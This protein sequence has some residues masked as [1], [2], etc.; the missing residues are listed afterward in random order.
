MNAV[1][2]SELELIPPVIATKLDLGHVALACL[3]WTSISQSLTFQ[4]IT[5]MS[6]KD[7][8]DF[9]TLKQH[10]LTKVASYIEL[11]ASSPTADNNPLQLLRIFRQTPV[12]R[13]WDARPTPARL[14]RAF[15]T[16]PH[17]HHK[18]DTVANFSTLRRTYEGKIRHEQHEDFKR[19]TRVAG[20]VAVLEWRVRATRRRTWSK[21]FECVLLDPMDEVDFDERTAF[22]TFKP[23]IEVFGPPARSRKQRGWF[24]VQRWS[25]SDLQPVCTVVGTAHAVKHTATGEE[26]PPELLDRIVRSFTLYDDDARSSPTRRVIAKKRDLSHVALVCRRWASVGQSLIF[27]RVALRCRTDVDDLV[28]LVQHP[29]SKVASYI[30][31]VVLSPVTESHLAQSTQAREGHRR[32][33][34]PWIHTISST[35]LPSI[36]RSRGARIAVRVSGSPTIKRPLSI[37][38]HRLP[39]AVPGLFS[40]IEYLA[41]ADM[42]LK[43][44]RDLIYVIRQLPSLAAVSCQNVTWGG[45]NGDIPSLSLYP[46]RIISYMMQG[47]TDNMAA[48]WLSFLVPPTRS[49]HWEKHDANQMCRLVS[50]LVKNCDPGWLHEC[51][52]MASRLPDH[53]LLWSRFGDPRMPSLRVFHMPLV[54]GHARRVRALVIEISRILT[55]DKYKQSNYYTDWIELD[56]LAASLPA[57]QTLLFAFSSREAVVQVH[58][59]V[60]LPKMPHFRHSRRLKYALMTLGADGM[61]QITEVY[62]EHDIVKE[63]GK[64]VDG[65]SRYEELL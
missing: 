16:P 8:D 33:Q 22:P 44:L 51:D 60:V 20:G 54:P 14:C 53:L 65:L 45:S 48:A 27:Q 2:T 47:C 46:A 59:Q 11:V 38:I 17:D 32:A 30:S 36:L 57:L 55:A 1:I 7:A 15:N 37:L 5:L 41:L 40:D 9:L 31:V 6:R 56:V 58:K 61:H 3:R 23:N 29:S 10:P 21:S 19:H 13:T 18:T 39:G 24:Q 62:C 4:R 35:P 64:P 63:K 50:S 25:H 26:V 52:I 12:E 49:D 42:H 43:T 28:A 34:A